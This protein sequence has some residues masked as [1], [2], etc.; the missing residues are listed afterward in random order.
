MRFSRKSS[1]RNRHWV[2]RVNPAVLAGA[3]MMF[4]AAGF[5]A[6][7]PP[8]TLHQVGSKVYCQC[9]CASTLNHCPHLPSQCQSKAQMR[10]MILADIRRGEAEP[11]VLQDLTNQ[12]GVRVLAAPPARGF[13]LTAWILPGV[14]LVAGFGFVLMLV[15]RWR[16]LAASN[17]PGSEQPVDAKLMAAV[18]EEMS[19]FE[20]PPHR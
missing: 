20:S 12:F 19:N 3:V 14:G 8:V 1:E 13:D 6:A 11:A 4:T 2:R 9:G 18:E 10:G 17:A 15:G 16:R 7:P 5:A